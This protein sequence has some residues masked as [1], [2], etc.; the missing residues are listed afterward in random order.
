MNDSIV[1]I[2]LVEDSVHDAEMT[3]RALTKGKVANS[4]IH[5][6]NGALAIEFLFGTGMYAGRN[7]QNKPKLILLD[8]KMPK[9]N[10]IEVLEKIKSNELTKRI[11]VV[12]LTSSKENPDI[13]KCYALGVNS[14]IVKPVDFKSFSDAIA[15]SGMY[16]MLFNQQ[17]Q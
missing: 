13:E 6:N 17:P 4:I 14:Y 10:G 9:V 2:L 3:I 7:T 5:L 1:E 12:M 15:H 11:P 8:L 16:W